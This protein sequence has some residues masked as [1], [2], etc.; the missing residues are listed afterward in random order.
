MRQPFVVEQVPQA[1]VDGRRD[2]RLKNCRVKKRQLKFQAVSIYVLKVGHQFATL[3]V[4][5]EEEV[6]V[7]AGVFCVQLIE[8]FMNALPDH[9]TD[10]LE[11][12]RPEKLDR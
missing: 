6:E 9:V 2:H 3:V 8:F 12:L 5:H 7:P 4:M 11:N 1:P 10:M